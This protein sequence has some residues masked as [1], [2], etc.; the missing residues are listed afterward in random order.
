MKYVCDRIEDEYAIL[1]EM[2]TKKKKKVNVKEIPT[3]MEG[4]IVYYMDDI[5]IIDYTAKEKR[6]DELR[7]KLNTLRDIDLD[8]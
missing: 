4:D 8:I 7:E 1:E 6:K 2:E 5:Y 3:I